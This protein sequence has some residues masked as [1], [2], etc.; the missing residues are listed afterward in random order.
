MTKI[1]YK[2]VLEILVDIFLI[3]AIFFSRS[4]FE[5]STISLIGLCSCIFLL[6]FKYIY[7]FRN[8]IKQL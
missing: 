4:R 1:S 8:R 6:V 7:R 2:V 3:Y 5:I